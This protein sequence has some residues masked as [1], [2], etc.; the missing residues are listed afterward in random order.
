MARSKLLIRL[1][2]VLLGG[3]G[4]RVKRFSGF[5]QGTMY[6]PAS[7]EFLLEVLGQ[8]THLLGRADE[9]AEA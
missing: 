4:E 2:A 3:C 8:F 7:E 5:A 1:L 6:H 9:V